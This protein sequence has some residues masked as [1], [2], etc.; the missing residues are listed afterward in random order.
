MSLKLKLQKRLAASILGCGKRRV[1][2]DP[3]E[4]S[5]ISMGT[6]RVTIRKLYKD[7]L[8]MRKPVAIHSRARVRVRTEA[9][10]KG[11]HMGKGKRK[12]TRE[13]RMPSKVLWMRRLRVLRRLL[14]KYRE[15]KK[16][17]KHIYHSFYMKSKGNQFKNKRVLIEAIHK[18]KNE[19]VKAKQ[20]AEQQEA[21]KE[22][23][24]ALKERRIAKKEEAARQKGGQADEGQS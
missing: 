9:K 11:R 4:T 15:T 3:N 16:I 8:I 17:D 10:R 18:A 13:A 14:R 21:R 19:K 22:K 5:E 24:R 12:G 7:G 23:A 2:L 6:S 20:I 1:W